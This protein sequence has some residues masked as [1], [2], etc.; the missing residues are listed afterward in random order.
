V[1]A[2][3]CA[4]SKWGAD[5]EL[6]GANDVTPQQVLDALKLVK[7]GETHRLGSSSI[8]TCRHSRRAR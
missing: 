8:R 2:Q 1:M 7:K 5:D 4:P 3:D 6:G